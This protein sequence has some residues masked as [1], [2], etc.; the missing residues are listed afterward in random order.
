MLMIG[1]SLYRTNCFCKKKAT[2]LFFATRIEGKEREKKD[3]PIH[4]FS[5]LSLSSAFAFHLESVRFSKVNPA[6]ASCVVQAAE[7]GDTL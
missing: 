1:N 5:L 2:L 4:P 3:A 7:K 6:A